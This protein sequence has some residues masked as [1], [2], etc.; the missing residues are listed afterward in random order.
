MVKIYKSQSK[1]HK[2]N[3]FVKFW[4]LLIDFVIFQAHENNRITLDRQIV[5]I[6]YQYN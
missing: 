4:S 1:G 6:D 3:Q 5:K 2:D